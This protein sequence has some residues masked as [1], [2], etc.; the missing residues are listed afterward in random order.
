VVITRCGNLYGPGD[1]NFNRLVPGTIRSALHDERPIIRS[2]G[3]FIR[4]YFFVRDAVAA[5]LSLAE[6]TPREDVVGQAFNFGT[7]TPLSVVQLVD[8]I[9]QLMDRAW[10]E[11][12]ILSEAT[13]EIP[14]QYLDCSKARVLLGWEAQFALEAGL[15]QTIEWYRDRVDR[16]AVSS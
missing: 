14:R 3:T 6:Q 9:L 13:N 16:V 5:Y 2:D 12:K 10:L 15:E 7:E 4:D 1:L 11:P 8:V